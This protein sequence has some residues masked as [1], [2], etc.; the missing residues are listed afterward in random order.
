VVAVYY[1]IAPSEASSN[2]ARYDGV[3]YGYRDKQKNSLMEMYRSTRSQGFGPEVQRR[4]IIGTYCLSAGYYD[5]YYGKASQVRTLIMQDFKKAF[6]TC[7]VIL[8]PVAPTPA[9][10][11]GEKTEDP[12]TMYLS[13]IFTLS[14]NLAGIPGMSVPCGFSRNHLPIG[15]QLMA[16]H[17]DEETLLKVAFNFEQATEFHKQRA[18]I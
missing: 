5:A 14:A 11:I 6:E 3:K 7:Q 9:F 18:K 12:L 4:I 8:A 17:F 10:K 13:D 1:V 15:L 16:E 2:L